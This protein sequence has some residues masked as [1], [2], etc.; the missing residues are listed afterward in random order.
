MIVLVLVFLAWD[1]NGPRFLLERELTRV[2][3]RPVTIGRLTIALAGDPVLVG[4]DVSI[5]DPAGFSGTEPAGTMA[6]ITARLDRAALL[7]GRVH[8]LSLTVEQPRITVARDSGGAWNWSVPDFSA[9]PPIDHVAIA[10]GSVHVTDPARHTDV[11]VTLRA[12]KPAADGTTPLSADAAGTYA[13]QPI[14]AHLV[15]GPLDALRENAKPYPVDFALHAGAT[16]ATVKGSLVNP[17]RPSQARL[18]ID[19]R[20]DDLAEVAAFVPIALPSSRPYHLTATASYADRMLHLEPFGGT[21]GASDVAGAITVAFAGARPRV[22]ADLSSRSAAF[23]D[24]VRVLGLAPRPGDDAHVISHAPIAIGDLTRVDATV[25]YRAARITTP[26]V[27]LDNG[28]ARFTVANG[29]LDVTALSAEA[30]GGSIAATL[31]LDDPA[32]VPHAVASVD[33]RRVDLKHFVPSDSVLQDTGRF[34]GKAQLDMTGAT[35][36]QMLGQGTGAITFIMSQGDMSAFLTHLP[37]VELADPVISALHLRTPTPIRCMAGDF[38]LDK[39][40][41]SSRVMVIDTSEGTF[42]GRGGIDMRTESIDY[43][44]APAPSGIALGSLQ[45][46]IDIKGTLRHPKVAVAS[47]AP[48]PSGLATALGTVLAPIEALIGEVENSVTSDAAC[49]DALRG[50]AA[51]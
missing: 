3:G 18:D 45:S 34:S 38:R 15:A 7:H 10:G 32:H 35:L 25:S 13:A 9:G 19:L 14:T 48:G 26:S 33:F 43:R 41:L 47:D 6:G 49:A 17:L 36:A 4:S 42:M 24:L 11:T 22:T 12:A 46:P 16:S 21:I 5:A 8:V 1:W 27:P 20:G 23:S 40:T 31:T 29:R 2:L 30:E 44:I 50:G 28:I 37:G 51:R 39:G